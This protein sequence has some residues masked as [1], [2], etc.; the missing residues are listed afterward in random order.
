M[1]GVL[2]PTLCVGMHTWV[3]VK[4]RMGS[5]GG[6][7]EPEVGVGRG[8]F[9]PAAA[10]LLYINHLH[11]PIGHDLCHLS[12]GFFEEGEDQQKYKGRDDAD[13]Q[14]ELVIVHQ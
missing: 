3:R 4:W 10:D 11:C 7:W 5:H 8:H 12:F 6:P 9:W 2:V 14:E 1:G 13:E